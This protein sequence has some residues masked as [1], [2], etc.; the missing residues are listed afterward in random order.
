MINKLLIF[1]C[2]ASIAWAGAEAPN[3]KDF[4]SWQEN[5]MKLQSKFSV[6][7]AKLLKAGDKIIDEDQREALSFLTSLCSV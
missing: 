4:D 6:L 5:R 3:T 7:Q 1:I 2:W